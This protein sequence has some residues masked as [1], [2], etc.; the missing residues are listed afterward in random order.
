MAAGNANLVAGD[1]DHRGIGM[2]ELRRE[3]GLVAAMIGGTVD[4]IAAEAEQGALANWP[5]K[6]FLQ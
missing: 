6:E 5:I 2:R 1:V 4:V 3:P